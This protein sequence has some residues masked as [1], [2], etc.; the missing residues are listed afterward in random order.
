[1]FKFITQRPLIVN[2]IVAIALVCAVFSIFFMSLGAITRHGDNKKVPDVVG[3]SVTEATDILQKA[4]LDV[5][6]QDSVYIDSLPKS[7][8]I[9]QSPDAE[10]EVKENRTIYLTINR[11]QAP[12]IDM[13]DLRGF[14]ITSA[15]LLLQS[16]GLKLGGTRYVSDVAKNAVKQQL[17][18]NGDINPGTKIPMGSS[19]FLI[20]GN[21][22]GSATL[23]VPDIT[24]MTLAEARDYLQT[25]GLQIG[26]VNANADV[27]SQ[28]DAYVY[29]QSPAHSDG[30][31]VRKVSPGQVISVWLS[32]Q[33]KGG[34]APAD[35]S[36]ANNE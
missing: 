11:A 28:D 21:G 27:T 4:G 24:G 9:K 10:A 8:I 33:P 5:S 14:S 15:Q 16:I 7:S 12:M 19:I 30:A 2:I 13:P 31:T 23:E 35:S 3:K 18:N 20:L 25:F 34:A 22:E 1:M 32:T 6:I 29:K 26:S 36:G 17:F